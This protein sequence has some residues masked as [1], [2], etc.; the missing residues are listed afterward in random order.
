LGLRPHRRRPRRQPVLG[1]ALGI[2]RR[3]RLR[4]HGNELAG[5]DDGLRARVHARLRR[6]RGGRAA[7]RSRRPGSTRRWLLLRCTDRPGRVARTGKF[8]AAAFVGWNRPRSALRRWRA[9]RRMDD[10]TVLGALA[11]GAW[12]GGGGRGSP[13]S[14]RSRCVGGDRPPPTPW[15]PGAGPPRRSPRLRSCGS[16]RALLPRGGTGRVGWKPSARWRGTSV[17]ALTTA[18][19][20]VFPPSAFR[21]MPRS[22]SSPPSSSLPTWRSERPWRGRP[23][24]ASARI[25]S[26]SRRLG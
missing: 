1:R 18:C 26:L 2:S 20:R 22:G 19:R 10:G 7:P 15:R 14:A 11:L 25:S 13:E 6:P 4:A 24:S 3:P 16:G 12:A 8:F 5:H 23:G 21:T 9:Q 17:R